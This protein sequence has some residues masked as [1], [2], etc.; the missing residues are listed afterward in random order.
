MKWIKS[1][2]INS[3]RILIE[4]LIKRHIQTKYMYIETIY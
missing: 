4:Y 3:V 1:N 2:S